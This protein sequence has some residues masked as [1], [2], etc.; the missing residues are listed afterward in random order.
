MASLKEILVEL[1]FK[2]HPSNKKHFWAGVVFGLLAFLF[3]RHGLDFGIWLSLGICV[4]AALVVGL[5]KETLDKI[6][7][8]VWDWLD[9][10]YTFAG[11][12]ITACCLLIIHA[13]I[14]FL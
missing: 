1:G 11:G 9:L 6:Q 13:L 5:G 2:P 8:K 12:V 4:S 7:G 3:V 10:I 14:M